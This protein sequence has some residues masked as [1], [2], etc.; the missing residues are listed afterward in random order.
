[1]AVPQVA[2][3]ADWIDGEDCAAPA[4]AGT[5]STKKSAGRSEIAQRSVR[6]AGWGNPETCTAKGFLHFRIESSIL[7]RGV[8]CRK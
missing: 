7:A 4:Q 3:Q 5:N 8:L 1:M 6:F 2:T